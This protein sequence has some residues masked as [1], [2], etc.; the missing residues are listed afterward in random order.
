MPFEFRHV[1]E[2]HAIDG[3]DG[4]R[5]GEDR[6][7]TGEALARLLGEMGYPVEQEATEERLR[8]LISD[9]ASHLVLVAT[10]GILVAGVIAGHLIP[11][12]QQEAPLGRITALAVDEDQRGLGVGK[13]LMAAAERWFADRGAGRIEITSA[14]QRDD[15]HQF[16]RSLGFREKRLRLVKDRH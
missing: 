15:A 10:V 9:P 4:G 14:E 5:D 16:F 3:A 2:I 7:P 12:L 13:R 6:R 8:A 11:M 1:F